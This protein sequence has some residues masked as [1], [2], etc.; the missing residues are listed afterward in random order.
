M[1]APIKLNNGKTQNDGLGWIV[2][3]INGHCIVE[4]GG[5]FQGFS[6]YIARYI[7]DKFTVIILTNLHFIAKAALAPMAHHVADLY[8]TT[9]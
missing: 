4:H 9:F 6:S 8:N 7:D 1:W 2:D 3:N 5:E